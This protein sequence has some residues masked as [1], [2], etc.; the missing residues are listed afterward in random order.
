MKEKRESFIP[1]NLSAVVIDMFAG[2][3]GVPYPNAVLGERPEYMTQD[4]INAL[5]RPTIEELQ[6]DPDVAVV[7]AAAKRLEI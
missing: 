7:L 3:D 2:K 6:Q 4:E 1:V 5:R